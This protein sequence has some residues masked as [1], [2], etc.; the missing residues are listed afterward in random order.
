MTYPTIAA[1]GDVLFYWMMK[2]DMAL[3]D[4]PQWGSKPLEQRRLEAKRLL[5]MLMYKAEV[6]YE[7]EHC[8]CSNKKLEGDFE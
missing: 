7:C 8:T 3:N 4:C 6:T 5:Y 2:L 1:E